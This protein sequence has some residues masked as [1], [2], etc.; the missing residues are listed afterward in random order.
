MDQRWFS[1]EEICEHLG[2]ARDTVCRWIDR[3]ALPA[4]KIG[5]LWKFKLD[6]VDDWVRSNGADEGKD[7]KGKGK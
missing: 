2:I 1:V 7:S 4:H 6:E 5:K 3:K